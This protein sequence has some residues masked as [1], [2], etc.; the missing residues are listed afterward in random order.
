MP[1]RILALRLTLVQ[2]KRAIL[3][4]SVDSGAC[5]AA[6]P[7]LPTARADARSAAPAVRRNLDDIRFLPIF[8][9]LAPPLKRAQ[10][11]NTG[12]AP[13]SK[14]VARGTAQRSL[15]RFARTTYGLSHLTLLGRDGRRARARSCTAF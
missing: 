4:G 11:S 7:A 2:S 13:G 1:P 3:M 6:T 12:R 8:V 15:V 14:C 5:A 10:L 9:D